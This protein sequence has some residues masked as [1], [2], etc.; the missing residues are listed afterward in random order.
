MASNACNTYNDRTEVLEDEQ[1]AGV[2]TDLESTTVTEDDMI[3][4]NGSD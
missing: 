3:E 4:R 1:V 2:L